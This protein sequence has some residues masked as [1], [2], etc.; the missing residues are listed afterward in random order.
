MLW[1]FLLIL[2]GGLNTV[3]LVKLTPVYVATECATDGAEL[4]RFV[5]GREIKVRMKINV[6]CR[7][8]NSYDVQVMTSHPGKVLLGEGRD[9]YVGN[10][11]LVSGSRLPGKGVGIISARTD[12]EISPR[13]SAVL[14]PHLLMDVELP[15]FVELQFDVGVGVQIGSR[16]LGIIAPFSKKCGMK[17]KGIMIGGTAKRLGP[18]VCKNSFEELDG[19]IPGV[20]ESI[21]GTMSF[22]AAQM[23]PVRIKM[24]EIAK[25]I[26]IVS[27]CCFAYIYGCRLMY[28][29]W[30]GAP[31]SEASTGKSRFAAFAQAWLGARPEEPPPPPPPLRPRGVAAVINCLS[32]GCMRSTPPP[33]T[34]TQP[35][36]PPYKFSL[37]A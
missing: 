27:I 2:Y 26:S 6:L 19:N 15:I 24:G 8:S 35:P 7:N 17:L 4:E 37:M 16:K 23:D 34:T 25:N 9:I 22:S 28:V 30:F 29:G 32:C 10:L 33:P 5:P 18:M 1:G 11:S 21:P 3:L 12:S 31:P 14:L 13:Q 36:R 20:E